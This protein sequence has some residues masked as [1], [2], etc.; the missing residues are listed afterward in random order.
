MAL[1]T[2]IHT[3]D[4]KTFQLSAPRRERL[5]LAIAVAV[6]LSFG[7]YAVLAVW[8]QS[9]LCIDGQRYFNVVDDGLIS[10]RYAWNLAHGNGLVWNPGE[11]VEGITNPGWA[12]YA[13]A[14]AVIFDRRV[15]PFAM[16]L[17]GVVDLLKLTGYCLNPEHPRGKHKARVFATLGF[18]AE[19]A[20][21]L[22]GR[23]CQQ[24]PQLTRNR[25]HPISSRIG[26]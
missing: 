5:A 14:L 20:E 2:D 24:L 13:A 8:R 21:E 15:L 12:L 4:A 23:C 18:T 11:R 22:A 17:T 10:L 7:A 16:Q 1:E 19:N 25:P 9:F 6:C 3:S 26:T